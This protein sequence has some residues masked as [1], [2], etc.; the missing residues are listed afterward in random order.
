MASEAILGALG[1]GIASLLSSTGQGLF[2][3]FGAKKAYERQN[4]IL[5]KQNAFA[6]SEAAKQRDASSLKTIY[7]QAKE[8]GLNTD[9]LYGNGITQGSMA[10][11]DAPAGGAVTPASMPYSSL[12]DVVSNQV[13]GQREIDSRIALNHALA[14]K[15]ES[16]VTVNDSTKR[17]QE[18]YGDKLI[19]DKEFTEQQIKESQERVNQM[20]STMQRF[21]DSMTSWYYSQGDYLLSKDAREKGMFLLDSQYKRFINEHQGELYKSTLNQLRADA[22]SKW[23]SG[24]ESKNRASLTQ[25]EIDYYTTQLNNQVVD[26][27]LKAAS[28]GRFDM[29]DLSFNINGDAGDGVFQFER[30]YND[31]D[32]KFNGT[33]QDE[34]KFNAVTGLVSDALETVLYTIML[35]RL[36]PVGKIAGKA[37]RKVH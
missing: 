10:S 31:G 30:S 1:S 23:M 6:A 32:V 26:L 27:L 11:A 5:D 29:S 28:T 2:S 36:G 15:Y 25:K 33:V 13:L 14:K 16:D 8:L 34:S 9:L 19:S 3:V 7:N 22:Y 17:M 35:R 37:L 21:Y 12:G 24:D 18:L 4:A 20:K